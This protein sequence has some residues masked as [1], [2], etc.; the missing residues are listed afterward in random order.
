MPN[1]ATPTPHEPAAAET[2]DDPRFVSLCL[3][4]AAIAV[5]R[6]FTFGLLPRAQRTEPKDSTA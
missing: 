6:V 1:A 2:P 3:R 5:L 4:F